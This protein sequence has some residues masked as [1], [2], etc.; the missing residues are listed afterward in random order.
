M[1]KVHYEQHNE[2]DAGV[3]E[4]SLVAERGLRSVTMS[5]IAQRV[6]IGRATVYKY[7]SDVESILLAWHEGPPSPSTDGRRPDRGPGRNR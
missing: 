4:I 5:E 1:R 7:F 6:G 3:E 2:A